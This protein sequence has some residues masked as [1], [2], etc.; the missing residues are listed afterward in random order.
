MISLVYYPTH[1]PIKKL[2]NSLSIILFAIS[3][4]ILFVFYKQVYFIVFIFSYILKIKTMSD[5]S[6]TE[7]D[8]GIMELKYVFNNYYYLGHRLHTID[9][10]VIT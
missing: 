10:L 5:L 6:S 1:S 8:V 3:L 9:H 2:K 7:D 4:L